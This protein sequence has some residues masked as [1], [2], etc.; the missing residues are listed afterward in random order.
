MKIVL[1]DDDDTA[2][3]IGKRYVK[4]FLGAE[5]TTFADAAQAEKYLRTNGADLIVADYSMPEM[6]GIELINRVRAGG[7]N[8][9]TPIIVVTSSAFESLKGKI[10]LAGAQDFL[11]KPVSPET[12][13]VRVLGRAG[14][15]VEP[16]VA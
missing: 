14:T 4:K 8:Q 3:A 1:I 7:P 16:A 6:N 12:F 5:A 11:C 13:K 15:P 2:L 10:M 9:A